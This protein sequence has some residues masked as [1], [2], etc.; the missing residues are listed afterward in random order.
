M[1]MGKA[2]RMIFSLAPETMAKL[3]EVKA[4]LRAESRSEAIRM[5]IRRVHKQMKDAGQ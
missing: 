2:P 5:V 3:D 4:W 1:D